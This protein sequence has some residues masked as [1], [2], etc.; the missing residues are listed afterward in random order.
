VIVD[1]DLKRGRH[2]SIWNQYGALC[3]GR[4]V[5]LYREEQDVMPLGKRDLLIT[6]AS[7]VATRALE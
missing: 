2:R 5:N 4:D 6:P 1:K 3:C 7:I